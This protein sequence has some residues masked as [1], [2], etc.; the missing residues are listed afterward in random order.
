MAK[1]TGLDYECFHD[2]IKGR[3]VNVGLKSGAVLSGEV[4]YVDSEI[5]VL[6]TEP[7]SKLDIETQVVHTVVYQEKVDFVQFKTDRQEA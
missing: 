6:V 4:R 1:K 2:L 7:K 3:D 5:L